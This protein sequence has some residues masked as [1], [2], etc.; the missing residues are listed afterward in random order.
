MMIVIIIIITTTTIP[1]QKKI[2]S[3][4]NILQVKAR[5]LTINKILKI[6]KRKKLKPIKIFV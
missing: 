2:V 4:C 1:N 3:F 5:K 6:L